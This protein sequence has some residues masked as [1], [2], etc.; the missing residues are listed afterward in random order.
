MNVYGSIA[1]HDFATPN[2]FHDFFSFDHL[3]GFRSQ[4]VQEFK[5]FSG[6]REG[7]PF[8]GDFV[9]FSINDQFAQLYFVLVFLLFFEAAQKA[10]AVMPLLAANCTLL[11]V[12]ELITMLPTF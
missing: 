4:K 1:N 5:F 3:I 6:Q 8:V 9:L 2:D 7:F 10:T 12:P 11:T